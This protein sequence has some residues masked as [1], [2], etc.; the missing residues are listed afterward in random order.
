MFNLASKAVIPRASIKGQCHREYLYGHDGE[1][2][3]HLS[4]MEGTTSEIMRQICADPKSFRPNQAPF[5]NFLLFVIVQLGRGLTS[6]GERPAHRKTH[7]SI[8]GARSL[9]KVDDQAGEAVRRIT[10]ALADMVCLT[11]LDVRVL[12]VPADSPMRFL[13]SDSPVIL[14][15]QFLRPYKDL[16]TL[17]IIAKGLQIFVPLDPRHAVH[18]FDATPYAVDSPDER[19]FVRITDA[20]VTE[21]NKLHIEQAL[22]NLYFHPTDHS[23]GS[24]RNQRSKEGP[25]IFGFSRV[26]RTARNWRKHQSKMDFSPFALIRSPAVAA[27]RDHL[28]ATRFR[29]VI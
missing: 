12:E 6:I 16:H 7:Q 29:D 10:T 24:I 23:L 2:E 4:Y 26:K 3:K 28:L 18:L 13:T 1:L 14:A 25:S 5:S 11:D 17:D 19:G 27:Q 15:N 22:S 9:F 20:D 21:L 8:Y